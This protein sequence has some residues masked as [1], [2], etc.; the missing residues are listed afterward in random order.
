[1]KQMEN[2]RQRV[3][4]LV[5]I[6]RL[7]S[8]LEMMEVQIDRLGERLTACRAEGGEGGTVYPL[9]Q[10]VIRAKELLRELR[11]LVFEE[12]GGS[13]AAG[14]QHQETQR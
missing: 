13:A 1:M 4:P 8:V 9:Y 10:L 7:M 5:V 3:D 6:D 14:P 2:E 11:I 12:C